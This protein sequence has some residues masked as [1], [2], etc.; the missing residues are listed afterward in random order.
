MR[1]MRRNEGEMCVLR[2]EMVGDIVGKVG[3]EVNEANEAK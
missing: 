2:G 3:K 1:R